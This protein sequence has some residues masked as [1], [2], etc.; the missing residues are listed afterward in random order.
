MS[1]GKGNHPGESQGLC[2]LEV[3]QGG[4][5]WRDQKVAGETSEDLRGWSRDCGLF[6]SLEPPPPY[7]KVYSDIYLHHNIPVSTHKF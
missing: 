2:R 5:V 7:C 6:L 4:G 3:A 1:V